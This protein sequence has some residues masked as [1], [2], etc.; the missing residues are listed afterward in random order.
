MKLYAIY[1]KYNEV[2]KDKW[3]LP[4]LNGEFEL[5]LK[6]ATCFGGAWETGGFR[7]A[8]LE[9]D[10]LIITA[11]KE[12]MGGVFV[13]SDTDIQFFKPVKSLLL[14]AI[15][16]Y[17]VVC[18]RDHPDKDGELC[19]GFF[20][21]R[22]NKDTLKLWKHV[23][24]CGEKEGKDQASFNRMLRRLNHWWWRLRY[25]C[26]K[27]K[28]NYLPNRFFGGGTTT[29]KYYEPGMELPIPQAMVLHHAN[30]T[31]RTENK[32]AQLE[33]VKRIVESR[34]NPKAEL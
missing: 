18:Q 31:V 13:Y 4:S 14:E 27:I 5:I 9:K 12:N 26:P 8:V 30:W 29:G 6:K 22:A 28:Y 21:I 7:D 2:L 3:F 20:V 11:I 19:T 15:K 1:S 32:I 34:R 23:R 16:G 10:D 17:D 25:L 24:K 33:Y